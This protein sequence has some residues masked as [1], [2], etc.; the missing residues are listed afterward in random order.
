MSS[1]AYKR[2]KLSLAV[3]FSDQPPLAYASGHDHGLQVI[4]GGVA[5]YQLV[6]GAGIYAHEGPLTGIAG[7]ELALQAA[8][9]MRVDILRDGRVRLGVVVVEKDGAHREVQSQWLAAEP[10]VADQG[11]CN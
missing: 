8:G 3:A 10:C 9:Y 11:N 5:H 2:M 7:A 4:Q 1:S 6:S